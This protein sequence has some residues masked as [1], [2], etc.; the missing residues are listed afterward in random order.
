MNTHTGTEE[1]TAS[2]SDDFRRS[3]QE[4]LTR[5]PAMPVFVSQVMGL[6]K[7]PD[8]DIHKIADHIRFDPGITANILKLA[9]SAQFGVSRSIRS[10]QEAIVRLGLKQLFQ[11]VV[12]YGISNRLA[13]AMPGYELRR[14][15]LLAHSLWTALAAEEFCK[16][17]DLETPDMMFTAGLL[18]DLGKLPLDEFVTQAKTELR[19]S[20]EQDKISFDAS[21]EKILG[22]DHAE[23][24]AKIL[25]L[26]NFP[27]PLVAAARWHHHPEKANGFTALVGIIHVAEFLAYEEGV[28]AGIDGFTY[29]LSD[30]AISHLKLKSR[31]IEYVASQTLDKMRNLEQL[32]LK[33]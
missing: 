3:I 1:N 7:S 13:K 14:E 28:G 16:V 8:V 2:S 24:G 15:E 4:R 10:L 17:L 29:R 20:M 26:W 23:A 9:N 12:A 27:A 11:L 31:T 19:K 21:E 5:F 32:L 33:P 22:M 18:H 25:D 6:V 30:E